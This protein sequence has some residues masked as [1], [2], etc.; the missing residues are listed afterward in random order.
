MAVLGRATVRPHRRRLGADARGASHGAQAAPH[1]PA[2]LDRPPVGRVAPGR[3][4]VMVC[5]RRRDTSDVS[6]ILGSA[7]IAACGGALALWAF[8]LT[9]NPAGGPANRAEATWDD[10]VGLPLPSR[11]SI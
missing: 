3:S 8:R 6:F 9:R 1:A 10:C 4:L 2:G 7:A 11:G 5:P